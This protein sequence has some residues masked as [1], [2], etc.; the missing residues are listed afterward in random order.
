MT[1]KAPEHKS[2]W[3]LMQ[4]FSCDT[5]EITPQF[6]VGDISVVHSSFEQDYQAALKCKAD[7]CKF[8]KYIY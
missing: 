5:L 7:W 2:A 4:I 6:S 3:R 1:P 8:T